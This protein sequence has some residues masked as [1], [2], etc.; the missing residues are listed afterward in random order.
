MLERERDIERQNC[1]L[2][3]CVS[4]ETAFSKCPAASKKPPGKPPRVPRSS[5]VC[6][7]PKPNDIAVSIS[8]PAKNHTP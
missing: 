1:V 3:D 8:K 7:L 2:A 4:I 5:H 6:R